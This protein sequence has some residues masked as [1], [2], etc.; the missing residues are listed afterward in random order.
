VSMATNL[1]KAVNEA[2]IGLDFE[3]H[4]IDDMA[5]MIHCCFGA[6]GNRVSPQ[7]YFARLVDFLSEPN[8]GQTLSRFRITRALS[9]G[10]LRLV[11]PLRGEVAAND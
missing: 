10:R 1:C 5:E 6:A 8:V 2:K 3:H 9:F 11:S 4:D 7:I